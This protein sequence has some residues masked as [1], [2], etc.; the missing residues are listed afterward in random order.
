[1]A[2]QI[3]LIV[4]ARDQASKTLQQIGQGLR[5]QSQSYRQL[6]Q[7][8]TQ[9]ANQTSRYARQQLSYGQ[10]TLRQT[11]QQ[12]SE[13]QRLGQTYQR[14][15]SQATQSAQ[16]QAR[17]TKE[18]RQQQVALGREIRQNNGQYTRMQKMGAGMRTAGAVVGGVTAA[19][20][21]AAQPIGRVMEYDRSLRHVANTV[22]DGKS[23]EEK[24]AG[25]GVINKRVIDAAN[26]GGVA[27]E[28]ALQTLNSMAAS[29][30]MNMQD[31]MDMLPHVTKTAMAAGDA[32][33]NDIGMIVV[34]A[35]QSGFSKADIPELL[36]RSVRSGMDGGFE[37]KDMAS[38]LPQQMA[39]MKNSG[40]KGMDDF[41]YVL[42]AN[43]L[44]LE[45]AGNADEA[46]NNL[47]NLMAKMT[48]TDTVKRASKIKLDGKDLDWSGELARLREEKGMNTL[49]GALNI[50]DRIVKSDPNSQKVANK[51]AGATDAERKA[52]LESQQ[53]IFK[54]TAIGELFADRQ[55]TMALLAMVNGKDRMAGLMEK[56][57][58]AKGTV[59]N[60]A[61]FV[62][63][64][65]DVK[66]QAGKNAYSEAEYNAF[67]GIANKIGE[68]MKGIGDWSRGNPN[69]SK[70][71]TLGGWGAASIGAA[72]ITGGLLSRL[73]GGGMGAGGLWQGGKAMA[74]KAGGQLMGAGRWA[75]GQLMQGG[76]SM[77]RAVGPTLMQSM[78]VGF[79][80][81]LPKLFNAKGAVGAGLLFHSEKL[82]DG[83][84]NK[85]NPEWLKAPQQAQ[86]NELQK[87]AEYFQ[88]SAQ[89][90]QQSS[91]QFNLATQ[92]Q[93]QSADTI[94]QSAQTL[95]QVGAQMMAAATQMQAAAAT[96][97]Q[98][99]VS[100]QGGNIMAQVAQQMS[101]NERKN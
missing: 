62:A 101:R 9:Y 70:A 93:Q 30:T 47:V 83:S 26:S 100:V 61:A 60:S 57:K 98:V 21:V 92:T 23:N 68:A 6:G 63:Q 58:S 67:D 48:S 88:Q 95:A 72:G 52:I 12:R 56:Q 11:V 36:D 77:W 44:S 19:G 96:P 2:S 54:G 86:G 33:P 75:G 82:G 53:D 34:K 71:L 80:E 50:V 81:W 65:A 87:T 18:A 79:T 29:G 45:T 28:A 42:S 38:W 69:A 4:R 16:Q 3:E 49:E 76:Q 89:T 39:L 41:S 7:S 13:V 64:G 22:Y 25:L 14:M 78:R 5:N 1:M 27:K 17:A 35:L 73:G 99:V 31:A 24:Q 37:L 15:G 43:Q 32:D 40:M 55:V 20:Y 94:N 85:Y 90:Q 46:G 66:A 8:H 74:G 84:M 97:Q 10:A 91:E 51:L 59:D